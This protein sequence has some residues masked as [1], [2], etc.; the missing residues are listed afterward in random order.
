MSF[1]GRLANSMAIRKLATIGHPILREVAF[2][3]DP[4]ELDTPAM[5]RLRED[6]VETLRDAQAMS[7]TA[8]QVHEPWAVAV[9][10]SKGQAFCG[11]P[12][13]SYPLRFLVNPRYEPLGEDVFDCVER[14][15]S[16]PGLVGRVRR[17]ARVQ[18]SALDETGAP[19]ELFVEG[20]TA[21]TFQR[22]IDHLDGRLFLDRVRDPRTLSG[23]VEF[24]RHGAAATQKERARLVRQYHG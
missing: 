20:L 5:R 7:L 11:V 13:P 24:R 22:A 6:L 19:L 10:E 1:F 18:V 23:E 12:E 8:P 21:A 14:C 15:A 17:F 3:V 16:V 9:V 2:P 4:A